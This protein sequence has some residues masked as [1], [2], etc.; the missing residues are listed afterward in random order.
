MNMFNSYE[1]AEAILNSYGGCINN[2]FTFSF[3]EHDWLK[4][5]NPFKDQEKNMKILEKA[6]F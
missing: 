1:E 3:S 5:L 6:N 4:L 2:H